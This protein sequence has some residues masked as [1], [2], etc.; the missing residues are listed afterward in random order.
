MRS[1]GNQHVQFFFCHVVEKM[2]GT[3]FPKKT[4]NFFTHSLSLSLSL[5]R[6]FVSKSH[7]SVRPV[8]GPAGCQ[9]FH[10]RHGT[11]RI[12]LHMFFQKTHIRYQ[13]PGN[14]EMIFC[15]KS[16]APGA[17]T[18]KLIAVLPRLAPTLSNPGTD[19]FG[20][21]YIDPF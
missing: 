6:T 19:F 1:E 14:S 21:F 8:K 3:P 5:S 13:N 17:S 18:D 11:Y 20:I 4:L 15:L 12:C 10:E 7:A 2:Y 16:S 9:L